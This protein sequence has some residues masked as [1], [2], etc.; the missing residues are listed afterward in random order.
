[1]AEGSSGTQRLRPTLEQITGVVLAGGRGQRMGGRDKGLE[2]HRGRPLVEQAL[3]R[4][5][6]QV[7][8]L[9]ISANRNLQSYAALGVPV[10]TDRWPDQ[11]GPLAG[12]LTALEHASTDWVVTV[13]CDTPDFP[14]DLVQRLVTAARDAEAAIAFARTPQRSQPVFALLHRSLAPALRTALAGDERRVLAWVQAQGAAAAP[15]EDEAAFRNL[16]TLD[17]LEP[18]LGP[19]GD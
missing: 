8:P 14:L 10:W 5:R 4:L 11:P 19:P 17:D 18:D 6:P 2:R 3:Q 7:G 12:W 1:M 16:N 9:A 15:F 13:P